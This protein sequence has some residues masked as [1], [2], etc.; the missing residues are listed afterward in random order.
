MGV[1][2]SGESL[3]TTVPLYDASGPNVVGLLVA[4]HTVHLIADLWFFV[5][6]LRQTGRAT[7]TSG[8]GRDFLHFLHVS[9]NK[10]VVSHPHD[11][12]VHEMG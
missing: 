5:P 12:H 9:L 1:T 2:G 4:K 6:Q 10:Q 7:V 11:A 3:T 8:T